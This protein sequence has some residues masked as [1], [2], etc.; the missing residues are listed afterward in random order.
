MVFSYHVSCSLSGLILTTP[1]QFEVGNNSTIVLD[2]V[3]EVVAFFTCFDQPEVNDLD[4][5][6]F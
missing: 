5:A 2:P 3:S 4:P 6:N 1:S